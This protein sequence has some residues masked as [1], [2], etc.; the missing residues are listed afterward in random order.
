MSTD[1]SRRGTP[2][3]ISPKTFR[4]LLDNLRTSPA[5]RIDRSYLDPMHSGSASAQIMS[6]LRYLELIDGI[7]KPTPRF[8]LLWNSEPGSDERAK[9]LRDVANSAYGFVLNN[10]AVNL[11]EATFLQMQTLFREHCRVEGDVQ[12]KC[13]KFFISLAQDAG[14]PLSKHISERVRGGRGE[15]QT[16]PRARKASSRNPRS[17]RTEPVPQPVTTVSQPGNLLVLE[18]LLEKFPGFNPSWTQAEKEKWLE[19]FS[20]VL[21]KIYP[22]LKGE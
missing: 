5:D 20:L 11:Q 17:S 22:E 18:K 16:R 4:T 9:R 10:P 21:R 12:R 15:T 3:Y 6:A 2:P 7:N 19:G 13:I 1:S 14:I 8:R